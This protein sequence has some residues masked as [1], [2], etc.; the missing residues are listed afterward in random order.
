MTEF[1]RFRRYP[2][3]LAWL[4]CC[5]V[6]GVFANPDTPAEIQTAADYTQQLELAEKQLDLTKDNPEERALDRSTLDALAVS[7][8][9][10]KCITEQETEQ[11]KL[12][13]AIATL[14]AADPHEDK[15]LQASR[16]DLE[17]QKK[18][19][20]KNL[21]QCRLLNV[22]ATQLQEQIS[23][24]KQEILKKR[25]LASSESILTFLLQ[26][27]QQPTL[28]ATEIQ[29]IFSTITNLPINSSNIY[30][31][32]VYGMFG[33]LMGFIWSIY[34]HHQY[35]QDANHIADTS[36][37]LAVVWRS[38]IRTMPLILLFGLMSLSL[39]YN[40]SG[41]AAINELASTL[42]LFSLSFMIISAML[43]PGANLKD[44]TPVIPETGRKLYFWARLLLI[45]MLFG[46]LF[47]S[48]LF[49]TTP[50]S[51]LV[52]LIRIALGTATCLALIRLIWLLR[53]HL[54]WL[55]H[56]R[57]YLL[58][59]FTLVV[60]IGALWL[61][62]RTLFTFLFTS[63]FG[64]LLILLVGWLLLRIPNEIFDGMDEGR[65]PWQSRLHAR[66]GLENQKIIPGLIWLRI[67]HSVTV[68][69]LMGMMLL[70][71]WGV[72]EQ[73][74][75]LMLSKLIGGF[76]IGSFTL[77]PVRI[78]GGLLLL[79]L[80]IGLTH[81]LKSSLANHWL[82]HTSLS[83]GAKETT[84]TIAGYVGILLAILIGLSVAGIEFTNLAIIAGALS[85][86]IGF[87]LQNIVN[88]F[89]S[90]LILLFERPIR[91]GD[92]IKVGTTEGYVRDISI[93]STTIQTFDR[94]DII[95]PNSELISNQV[96]NMMLSNQYGRII[97]PISVAYDSE[98]EKVMALLY[99]VAEKHPAILREHGELKVQVFFR[100]FAESSLNFE[101]RCLIKDVES[102]TQVISELNLAIDKILRL[103]SIEMP[104][105]QRTV[106]VA[107]TPEVFQQKAA[108]QGDLG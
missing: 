96:T 95:V 75:Q 51:S 47:H 5:W 14:G 10:E 30:L 94:S 60:A 99:Q 11:A 98:A 65:A 48:P 102:Q 38:I 92:W 62:Y 53:M 72:S 63:T 33:M 93:R 101:L 85:V 44:F 22:R 27:L 8:Y 105:P 70:R 17:K 39:R 84:T 16:R 35:R 32:L 41:V 19:V 97:I 59:S 89:V 18:E 66:L 23:L 67:T 79:A 73:S 82:R 4:L 87:G 86:G 6:N 36:P 2:L 88:N 29:H 43:R 103:E 52:G 58:G 37:T 42:F 54:A 100:S 81:L 104:C 50:P 74:M 49:D 26:A 24:I 15:E 40:P 25:L 56:L 7:Q 12:Q 80:L 106:H 1:L 34:K 3:L 78:I 83:R 69:A 46:L 45:T 68:F 71:L 76:Q 20:E 107:K 77:Q 31:A 90:G 28:W 9:A 55:E 21:S 91:R 61:G 64:A 13:N 108:K 57:I